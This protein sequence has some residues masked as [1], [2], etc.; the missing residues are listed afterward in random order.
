MNVTLPD[1]RVVRVTS[2]YEIYRLCALP[3]E[4]A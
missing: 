2:E 4:A 3:G 1:G